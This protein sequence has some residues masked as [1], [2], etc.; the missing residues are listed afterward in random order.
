MF[1]ILGGI[2]IFAMSYSGVIKGNIFGIEDICFC[3]TIA[4]ISAG[5]DSIRYKKK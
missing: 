5:L 1:K 2:I 4:L 3:F